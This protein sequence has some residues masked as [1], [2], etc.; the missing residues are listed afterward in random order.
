MN[1]RFYIYFIIIFFLLYLSY[2]FNQIIF[3][4]TTNKNNYQKIKN[5]ENYENYE[6][7]NSSIINDLS[8]ILPYRHLNTN[9]DIEIDISKFFLEDIYEWSNILQPYWNYM[10]TPNILAR[11]A[12]SIDELITK[13][14]NYGIS[15]ISKDEKNYVIKSIQSWLTNIINNNKPFYYYLNYWIHKCRLAKGSNWLEDGMPHTHKDIIIMD[16]N[17]FSNFR[18]STFLHE[19]IHIHQ[20]KNPNDFDT[21]IKLLGFTHYNFNIRQSSNLDNILIRNRTNP[22]GLDINYLWNL[23]YTTNNNIDVNNDVNNVKYWIGAVYESLTPTSLTNNIDYIAVK[24]RKM[25]NGN[26]SYIGENTNNSNDIIKLINFEIFNEF[27]ALPSN[28]NNYHPNEI[29]AD[30]F[31]KYFNNFI[32]NKQINK[33][34]MKKVNIKKNGYD[35]FCEYINNILLNKY[36]PFS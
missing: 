21:L 4:K 34:K 5:I 15:A 29:I 12:S 16:T 18:D 33:N 28:N 13:Y 31:I 3:D 11:K 9:I 22:D 14:S 8:I 1:Y 6:S 27:M 17:W 20:R 30:Y 24:L 26:Y 36:Q 19:L 32:I 35:I 10:N 7:N 23:P 2:Y 25:P